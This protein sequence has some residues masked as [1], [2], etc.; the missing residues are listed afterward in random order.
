MAP[1]LF[2]ILLMGVVFYALWRGGRDERAVALMC[3]AGTVAT[4]GAS[5]LGHVQ[6]ALATGA[7]PQLK[8]LGLQ[9]TA[10]TI[11]NLIYPGQSFGLDTALTWIQQVGHQ[12]EPFWRGMLSL[13]RVGLL[14]AARGL[15]SLEEVLSVTLV[16]S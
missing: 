8:A 10:A 7:G 5:Y 15:S 16:D 14:N 4:M 12:E 13:R 3:V 11:R 1:W 9:V 2:R 6:W